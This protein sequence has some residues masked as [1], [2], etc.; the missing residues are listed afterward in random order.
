MIVL[1]IASGNSSNGIS[2]IV[3]AQ[4]KSLQRVGVDVTYF[5]ILGKG[6]KGYLKN[7]HPLERHIKKNKYDIIHAHYSLSALVASLAGCRPL[8]V[9]LM[10]SDIR[11]GFIFSYAVKISAFC[12]WDALIVK[13]ADMLNHI[14]LKKSTIIPNGVDLAHFKPEDKKGAQGRL[15]WNRAKEHVL[16]AANPTIAV[17][18][19][20]L[21]ENALVSMDNGD[22]MDCHVLGNIAHQD[23]PT[24]MNAADVVVLTS[25]REGSPNV[26]KEAM[27]CNCPIVATDVGDVR[28]VVGDTPGCYVSSFDP[29]D[30]A[31]KLMQALMFA[32]LHGKTNGRD[33]IVSLGLDSETVARKIMDVYNEA[34]E[35]SA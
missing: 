12:L 33:R 25:L 6:L 18:N 2:P 5:P 32:Q 21:L 17:K 7:V 10:G 20:E 31:D 13:S 28:W 34:L 27:A 1:F 22:Q 11:L 26:V 8:V 9:S 23:I 30:V 29:A 24:H 19:F 15:G 4:G 35:K 3:R 16:F 14:G